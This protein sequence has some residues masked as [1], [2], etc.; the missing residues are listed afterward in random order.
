MSIWPPLFQTMRVP[1]MNAVE[2]LALDTFG[3]A[4]DDPNAPECVMR[5]ATSALLR[6]YA[7]GDGELCAQL[8]AAI[9]QAAADFQR[10]MH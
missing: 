8:E 6:L 1:G 2:G 5:W 10:G 7:E 9:V 3:V 4:A